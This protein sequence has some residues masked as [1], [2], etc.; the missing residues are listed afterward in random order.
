MK[1][2]NVIFFL[3]ANKKAVNGAVVVVRNWMTHFECASE[4]A[5]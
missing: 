4:V 3:E 2:I 5:I 1:I